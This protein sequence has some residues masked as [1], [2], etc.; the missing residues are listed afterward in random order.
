MRGGDQEVPAWLPASERAWVVRHRAVLDAIVA[1]LMATGDWPDPV[2]LERELRGGG[3]G[4]GVVVAIG[5]MPRSLGWREHSPPRVSLTLFGLASASNGRWLI[6]SLYQTLQLALAR[7]DAPDRPDRLDRAFV[8]EALGLDDRSMDAVSVVLTHGGNPFL[9]GGNASPV[10]WDLQID[11]RVVYLDAVA[12][13]EELMAY[14]A[15]ER[16]PAVAEVP[17]AQGASHWA[18]SSAWAPIAAVFLVLTVAATF[19]AV[20]D[21]PGYLVAA[22]VVAAAAAVMVHRHLLARPPAMWAV[23]AVVLAAGAGASGWLLLADR[24]S[25]P[26][27]LSERQVIERL[28]PVVAQAKRSQL[29]VAFQAAAA[30]RGHDLAPSAV[31]VLRDDRVVDPHGDIP[32]DSQGRFVFPRSDELRV[33][34]V[35]GQQLT[36]SFDFLPQAPGEIRQLPEGDHPAFHIAFAAP[37]DIDNDGHSE[38]LG[39]FL[40]QT[41]ASGPYPVPFLLHWDPHVGRFLVEP[42]I[43]E[44]PD[45]R[46]RP[47]LLTGYTKPTV[48]RDRITKQRVLGYATDQF[49][50]MRKGPQPVLVAAY[51]TSS[52]SGHSGAELKMWSLDLQ[53]GHV[54]TQA[55]DGIFGQKHLFASARKGETASEAIERT[56]RHSAGTPCD[57]RAFGEPTN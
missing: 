18:W 17:A 45:L 54:E 27:R 6:G 42:L 39:E 36:A 19:A 22:T 38:L 51:A 56:V 23:A 34:D 37:A 52:F 53:S 25:K 44:P 28:G 9:G 43:T 31:L 8:Q 15:R 21:A 12:S 3:K 33:Y 40:R 4:G 2:A 55:C 32:F 35:H 24:D 49:L 5:Q 14:L 7:F 57:F 26:H 1:K 11:E 13:A 16:L 10:S 46:G 20:V 47:R 41:M 48:I 30:L 50:I 29:S